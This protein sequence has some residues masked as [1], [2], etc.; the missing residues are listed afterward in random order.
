[1]GEAYLRECGRFTV[2][3]S[4]PQKT[5]VIFRTGQLGDTLVAMPAIQALRRGFPDHRVVLL[6]DRHPAQHHYISPWA[7]L[8]PT[9]WV[10]D[11]MFYTPSGGLS[12]SL[13]NMVR[14]AK[15]IRR[16]A[17]EYVFDLSQERSAWQSR[18]DRFFFRRLAGVQRYQCRGAFTDKKR[19]A[20]GNLPRVEPE[21]KTLMRITGFSDEGYAFKMEV[22]E[23]ERTRTRELLRSLHIKDRTLL[24]AF[25]PGSKRP[26]TKWPLDRFAELG[27]LLIQ[28]FPT[29]EIL[30]LGGK[31]D[32]ETGDTLCAEWGSRCH[33]LAGKL[34]VYGS[35][36]AMES[37]LTFVGNDTG[38][39]HLAAMVGLPCVTIFSA[40]NYPGQW[41]PYGENNI[42]LRHE[43][44]CSG[45]RLEVC[46]E[47]SNKC[48]DQISVNEVFDAVRRTIYE[49][50]NS[51]GSNPSGRRM[52]PLNC[53]R[54]ECGA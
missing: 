33:N 41:E 14:T 53:G 5:I 12:A 51:D 25:G 35:A 30:I 20:D 46:T 28:T 19:G 6:T 54:G 18:R 15:D 1:M 16:L 7:L 47:Y 48:L 31:E 32:A 11:V 38:T 3:I 24:V 43:T 29:L 4:K 27:R 44:D 9:G 13:K 10:D 52:F 36:A 23:E 39:M 50:M 22:P 17:P 2:M 34:S 45:C 26:T 49:R 40:R 42:V 21:W 8:G 37:C